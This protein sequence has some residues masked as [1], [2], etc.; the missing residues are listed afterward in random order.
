MTYFSTNIALNYNHL[1]LP[2]SYSFLNKTA[3]YKIAKHFQ[4]FC[5]L[6]K[7]ATN[8]TSIYVNSLTAWANDYIPRSPNGTPERLI[9]TKS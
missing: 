9:L 8:F 4:A 6:S 7:S 2:L 3:I 1:T 5:T